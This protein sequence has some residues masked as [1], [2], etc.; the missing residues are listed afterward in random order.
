MKY[1]KTVVTALPMF[2]LAAIPAAMAQATQE[3]ADNNDDLVIEEVVVTGTRLQNQRA[4]EQK[5]NAEN[6]VDVITADDIGSLPDFSVAEALTRVSGVSVEERNG[7]AE[8]V[9]VRGLRSDFNY[10]SIDGGVVPSTR[11]G[12]RATQL[13]IIPSYVIK[14][15]EV[16][17]SFSADMDGNAIGGQ[18]LVNTRSAYDQNKTYFAARGGLGFFEHD[19]GPAD[20]DQAKRWD[21][22]FADTFGDAD[23]F[24]VVISGSHLNQDYYTYLPGVNWGEYQFMEADGSLGKLSEEAGADAIRVP[25]G[26][27]YYLYKN[28]IERL[29]GLVKLEWQPNDVFYAA[30]TAYSFEEK[31]SEDRWAGSVYQDFKALE[32]VTP[33]SGLVTK[34]KLYQAYFFQGDDNEVNSVSL[35]GRWTPNYDSSVDFL[36]VSSDGSRSNPFDE[37]RFFAT[38]DDLAYRYD[39]SGEFPVITLENPAAFNDPSY[40]KANHHKNWLQVNDQEASQAKVDYSYRMDADAGFGFKTGVSYR[41][42]ERTQDMAYY[43]EYKP[44]S[45]E[46]K[47]LTPAEFMSGYTASF[48]PDLMPG[49]QISYLDY[50]KFLSYWDS[51]QEQWRDTRSQADEMLKSEYGV[52]EEI[53]AA[54]LMGRYRGDNLHFNVGMRY[55]ETDLTSV[56]YREHVDEDDSNDTYR[57]VTER[58][59]YRNWLPS[60][61]LIWDLSDDWRLRASYSRSLGRAEYKDLTVLGRYEIDHG[62]KKISIRSDNPALK[63]RI[64]DNFDLSLEYYFNEIDGALAFG[65]YQK[66]IENE[67]FQRVANYTETVNGEAYEVSDRRPDNAN[68]AKLSGIELGFTLNSFDFIAPSLADVGFTLNYSNI[69]SEFDIEMND[70]SLRQLDGM[71]YQPKNIAQATLFWTPNKFDFKLAYR[72]SDAKL[73]TTSTSSPTYDEFIGDTNKLDFHASY[74]LGNGWKAFFDARNLLNDGTPRDLAYGETSWSRDYGRSVWI[75]ASYK[76]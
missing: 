12:G 35:S 56:G 38:S 3:A 5:R 41:E 34:G 13:S 17:K 75:G 23:Q 70:G 7:D 42:D 71:V 67:I 37:F 4:L 55:E 48:S 49:Q 16:V 66:D 32:E 73:V 10:L 61:N 40:L 19:E 51:N 15:T 29:G 25:S 11:S 33:T 30:L 22:A 62:M 53:T 69:D 44:N 6:I 60:A 50:Q 24:G 47:G 76:Y 45:A 46:S 8:F 74:K 65:V 63:P 57:E 31:D 72:Y 1:K 9:V 20:T 26:N 39:S 52:K 18:I 28:Q 68:S 14:N 2:V 59:S 54:Y 36:V 27:Q 58:N 21:F 43:H 64:S